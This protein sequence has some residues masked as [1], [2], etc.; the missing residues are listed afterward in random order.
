[1]ESGHSL[2]DVVA[3]NATLAI[4]YVL[5]GRACLM[6]AVPPGYATPIFPPAGIAI[7]GMFVFGASTLPAAFVGAC[8][9]NIWNGSGQSAALMVASAGIIA[10][11]S[12]IQ[13]AVGGRVLR[14]AIG[15][16]APLDDLTHIVRFVV[17]SPVICLASASLSL[18]GLWLI[19]GIRAS[20]LPT[21]WV[22]WWVGD[23]LGVLIALPLFLTLAGEPHE[24]WRKRRRS[25]AIPLLAF[26]GLFV[27]MFVRVNA[28]EEDQSL[29]EF[30]ILSQ[31]LADNFHASLDE[32]AIVLDQL[33]AGVS[34][35]KTPIS[36]QNF[37]RLAGVI[38][39]RFPTV[40]AV[41]WAPRV[42]DSRR[43]ALGAV[44]RERDSAG[45][46]RAAGTR[47]E[48]YPVLYVYPLTGNEAASGYDL[49]SDGAR[50]AAVAQARATSQVSITAPIHLVQAQADHSG[51]LI[52]NYVADGPGG[53]G[54]LV[55][56]LR[57][58][59]FVQGTMGPLASEITARISD[60][61]AAPPLFDSRPAVA[62]TVLSRSFAFGGRHYMLTTAPTPLYLAHHRGWQGWAFVAGGILCTAL[63]GAFLMLGTGQSWRFEK[64][65][66]ARTQDLKQSHEALRHE[67]VERRHAEEA[68][69]QAQRMRAIGQLT[70]GIAHDFNNLLMVVTGSVER[71]RGKF[72]DKK[73]ESY[74]DMIRVAAYRGQNLTRQLLSFA[75]RRP[76][77]PRVINLGAAT[78]NAAELI[79][80]SLRGDI[81]VQVDV[82]A[83][84]CAVKIDPM[85]YELAL[86]NMSIN[87]RDAMPNGGTLAIS[88]ESVDI[89]KAMDGV[90]GRCFAVHVADDG[91]GI[92]AD[93]LPR[94]FEP[95]FTTKQPGTGTGLGL[96]QVYGFAKQ[97]SGTVCIDSVTGKG[98]KVTL[99]FPASAEAPAAPAPVPA[100]AR[101]PRPHRTRALI[102][103]DETDVAEVISEQ[104]KELGYEV[105]A[106]SDVP[107]AFRR[108]LQQPALDIIV[109]DILMPGGISGID[110]A[111][112]LRNEGA[113]LPVLLVT[114]YSGGDVDPA[115]EGFAVL[116][117]PF[118]AEMLAEAIEALLSR[119]VDKTARAPV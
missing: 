79:R 119:T 73:A 95:Y 12:C 27:V 42:A 94:V 44:I 9:L 52:M 54:M 91:A 86:L 21:S 57:M 81:A 105:E 56:V 83:D 84:V 67:V 60:T 112:R 7:G 39:D 16:P 14:S 6:L 118:E 97:S 1:M 65:L 82:P 49:A 92:P 70:G 3:R 96:S 108:I 23:S 40:Q 28:W 25:L 75:Q 55:I 61:G 99:L 85:E 89:D 101:R 109:S 32:I 104:L 107:S 115:G 113:D 13:A 26:F 111:R 63:L 48:Y 76:L 15:Y 24:L 98:T 103:E 51:V 69:G 36:Q 19:G 77:N 46:M 102:V 88:V 74:L 34:S 45:H 72:A 41:E 71:L 90:E 30:R 106:V 66:D 117:K 58:S 110:L 64:L 31:K 17:L 87:A 59:R 80:L 33:K 100:H 22:A 20:E 43:T 35:R 114:G 47:A 2:K 37:A 53:P 29:T 68:L 11:A 38:L 116:R 4:A 50:R 62:G 18:F 8:I 93:V 10:A 5:L 78:R